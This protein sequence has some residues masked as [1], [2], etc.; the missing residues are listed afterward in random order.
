MNLLK[1]GAI[2]LAP[3]IILSC[4]SSQNPKP[5]ISLYEL[6]LE[7]NQDELSESQK[8]IVSKINKKDFVGLGL[9]TKTVLERHKESYERGFA[10]DPDNDFSFFEDDLIDH[11][12]DLNEGASKEM[13]PHDFKMNYEDELYEMHDRNHMMYNKAH[14]S[15]FSSVFENRMQCYSGTV[16]F[17][18]L[19]RQEHG[20]KY[21]KKNQVFI[22]ESGHVLPGYVEETSGEFS[23]F[24]VE[25]TVRGKAK[26][27]FGPTKDLRGVRV[28]DAHLAMGLQAL[29]GSILN[30]QEV[31]QKALTK[32][33][34][35][36]NIP[37]SEIEP[38]LENVLIPF[39]GEVD[40]TR[41]ARTTADYLNS[42]IF[43]FGDSS[44]V[45]SGDRQR[46]EIDELQPNGRSGPSSLFPQGIF[47][48]RRLELINRP[49]VMRAMPPISQTDFFRMGDVIVLIPTG[50]L[51]SALK[52]TGFFES[53]VPSLYFSQGEY[54]LI[55]DRL[56]ISDAA[57]FATFLNSR[58]IIGQRGNAPIIK[59]HYVVSVNLSPF[60]IALEEMIYESGSN[61]PRSYVTNHSTDN[62][63]NINPVVSEAREG[64]GYFGE[65]ELLFQA[66][67]QV[68][69]ISELR[70]IFGEY[71]NVEVIHCSDETVSS[72]NEMCPGLQEEV[73]AVA[74]QG[75]LADEGDPRNQS[76]Y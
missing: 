10:T 41:V 6:E 16:L 29:N 22:Y 75:E 35:L 66:Y 74:P 38:E 64:E 7:V 73:E 44:R 50:S 34:E 68:Y 11:F 36:Y 58:A 13:D 40:N 3:F 55:D 67:G 56:V 61:R 52:D 72:I 63:L 19:Y 51:V 26:K 47:V 37:I 39:E 20:T 54:H 30:P 53:R 65:P 27:I 18:I 17:D 70:S 46:L 12:I 24:G 25:T 57:S 4:S 59:H 71:V 2:L 62:I 60:E 48:E 15:V 31:L 9:V 33:A 23:L 28:V 49:D 42:S 45:P 21:F 32:T 1:S 69:S 8:K 14:V 43:S 5:K 76:P